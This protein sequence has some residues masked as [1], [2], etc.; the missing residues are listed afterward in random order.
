LSLKKKKKRKNQIEIRNKSF[1]FYRTKIKNQLE[2]EQGQQG[3]K[4]KRIEL[5]LLIVTCGM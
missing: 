4:G 5:V 2:C 3:D 1:L